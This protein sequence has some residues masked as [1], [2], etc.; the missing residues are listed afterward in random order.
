[1]GK[2]VGIVTLYDPKP[3]Y[4]NRL[5]NLA[6]QTVLEKMGFETVTYSF[7]KS[8]YGLKWM[9]KYILQIISG[10]RLSKNN[11]YGRKFHQ[12]SSASIGLIDSISKLNA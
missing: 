7:E 12:R 9:V 4:G 11:A 1:M 5:Q 2:S 10:Y 6:V 3:N 8:E